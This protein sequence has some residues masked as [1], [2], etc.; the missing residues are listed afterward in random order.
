MQLPFEADAYKRYKS[1]HLFADDIRLYRHATVLVASL[2]EQDWSSLFTDR[3]T[4]SSAG[5]VFVGHLLE[6]YTALHELTNAHVVISMAKHSKCLLYEYH[7]YI[8]L[9]QEFALRY[10]GYTTFDTAPVVYRMVTRPSDAGEKG[11]PDSLVFQLWKV[12][13]ELQPLNE[14]GQK[15]KSQ[16]S[17]R[18]LQYLCLR[19]R[20]AL[21][22][23]GRF[24]HSSE[25]QRY[26]VLRR[27][28]HN[29]VFDRTLNYVN[30]IANCYQRCFFAVIE[31]QIDGRQWTD[32][33]TRAVASSSRTLIRENVKFFK[34]FGLIGHVWRLDTKS[35]KGAPLMKPVWRLRFMV[36]M[37]ADTVHPAIPAEKLLELL[38]NSARQV[39][40]L[41]AIWRLASGR[42][43]HL[44][45]LSMA[46]SVKGESPATVLKPISEENKTSGSP[47]EVYELVSELVTSDFYRRVRILR[48]QRPTMCGRG[49]VADGREI[50]TKPVPW[51]KGGDTQL[52]EFWNAPSN[53]TYAKIGEQLGRSEE[54]IIARLV[55]LGI[56]QS[57]AGAYEAGLQRERLHSG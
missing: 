50:K 14:L 20:R 9:L 27:N 16:F 49:H 7:P 5:L 46:S 22:R 10:H 3:R 57:H 18:Q 24:W 42:V 26:L 19:M 54:E 32:D 23:F 36:I 29:S 51:S 53:C 17:A 55:R 40:S 12:V 39:S 44:M 37:R 34:R 8:E 48:G 56:C 41:S 1:P 47:V 43:V 45:A 52:R 6:F 25:A 11:S 21:S 33:A 35:T 31:L 28:T 2:L 38:L 15:E 4:L 13:V 30:S